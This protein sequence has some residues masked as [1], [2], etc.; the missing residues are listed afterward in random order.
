MEKSILLAQFYHNLHDSSLC[1]FSYNFCIVFS[2]NDK[3]PSTVEELVEL[4]ADIG[5]VYEEKLS[6]RKNELHPSLW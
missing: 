3:L 5:D 4:V 1:S 2:E 6:S